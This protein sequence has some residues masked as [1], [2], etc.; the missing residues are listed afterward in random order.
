LRIV[1]QGGLCKEGTH[2][3]PIAMNEDEREFLS[4]SFQSNLLRTLH[5]GD[6]FSDATVMLGRQ[7]SGT[8]MVH[9]HRNILAAQSPVFSLLF[10]QMGAPQPTSKGTGKV[11]IRVECDPDAFNDVLIYMYSG[12]LSVRPE[13]AVELLWVSLHYE[14]E[15]LARVYTSFLEQYLSIE[16]V[17]ILLNAALQ[18]N[19]EHLV[20]RCEAFVL[21]HGSQT[22]AHQSFE[23]LPEEEVCRLLDEDDLQIQEID[24]FLAVIRWG[25]AR[26]GDKLSP[27]TVKER[28]SSVMQHIRFPMI[29]GKDLAETV[30]STEMVEQWLLLE[31]YR[32]RATGGSQGGGIRSTATSPNGKSS[33]RFVSRRLGQHPELSMRAPS[34]ALPYRS[35]MSMGGSLATNPM[36]N[37][38]LGMPPPAAMVGVGLGLSLHSTQPGMVVTEVAAWCQVHSGDL[39]QLEVGD[40]LKAIDGW[41]VTRD[42][43][44]VKRRLLGPPSTLVTLGINR[45]NADYSVTVVRGSS[46]T[47]RMSTAPIIAS[48]PQNSSQQVWSPPKEQASSDMKRQLDEARQALSMF[49]KSVNQ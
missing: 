23:V 40:M 42:V 2:S 6:A 19:L 36:Q 12:R 5:D 37:S 34:L 41:A 46:D 8:S 20:E 14:M 27:S 18:F 43:E 49:N 16:T 13:H 44:A 31:C 4:D 1:Y 48:S 39:Q 3:K 11:S 7:G 22:F 26:H 47:S 35:T 25:K 9:C 32:F 29:E 28:L 21:R 30:E 10:Q 24:A 33:R 45:R 15:A 38:I 17:N